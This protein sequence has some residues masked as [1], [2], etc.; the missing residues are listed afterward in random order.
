MA[1]ISEQGSLRTISRT[2]LSSSHGRNSPLQRASTLLSPVQLHRESLV[3]EQDILA[4]IQHA[5]DRSETQPSLSSFRAPSYSTSIRE[6]KDTRFS[7]LRHTMHWKTVGII[8]S[9]LFAGEFSHAGRRTLLTLHSPSSRFRALPFVYKSEPYAYRHKLSFAVPGLRSLYP[10]DHY[11]QSGA[12]S[13]CW[14]LLCA[15]PMARSSWKRNTTCHDREIIH[16][17]YQHIGVVRLAKHME[18]T[19][20][21][22]YGSLPLV[23]WNS[24]NLSSGSADCY[25]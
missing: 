17:S 19:F 20:A 2:N 13:M 6:G 18:S 10:S 21:S 4:N 1:S 9:F 3:Q 22:L 7:S 12:D 15:T 8:I 5:E 14:N 11:L 25:I 24:D 23:S 16:T